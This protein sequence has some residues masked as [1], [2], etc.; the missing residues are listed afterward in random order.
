MNEEF[1]DERQEDVYNVTTGETVT[2]T[3][4]ETVAT[5]PAYDYIHEI[6]TKKKSKVPGIVLLIVGVL[7]LLAGIVFFLM[8]GNSDKL[9]TE[10]A[11]DVYFAS[12]T[13]QYSS[14][15]VQY[16]TDSVASYE[17]MDNM[18]F[19]IT[20]DSEWNPA[21][22]CMHTDELPAFM[23]YM[24]WF[25]SDSEEGAPEEQFFAGYAQPIDEELKEIVIES[26][27]EIFGED[28]VDESN[29]TEWFGEYYLQIG[30]KNSSYGVSNVGIAFLLCA[31]LLIVI[32]GAL[33]YEKPIAEED[34]LTIHKTHTGLGIL[35]AMLGAMLGG[36][37]W[38]IIGA[39][40]F[41][42]GWVGI[43][44]IF[45]AYK[46]YVILARKEGVFGIVISIIF[47]LIIVLPATYLSYGWIYYCALN[48]SVSGYTTLTRALME[49]PAYLTQYE[50]W[51]SFGGDVL[52]GYGFMIFVCIIYGANFFSGRKKEKI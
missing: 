45:F 46:G 13:D 12:S 47:G 30:Q 6:P 11:M 49:L 9:E 35:G 26:F 51:G 24:D 19:F 34:G 40:G 28:I 8:G 33:V 38:T 5:P 4:A 42:S 21:I 36:L 29:F 14:V 52:M 22:V 25:Y 3:D 37:V 16:M 50:E 23:P 7:F 43:L 15:T 2:N 20:M 31:I 48:E 18:Q 39:A 41:V 44:I 1:R 32:G 17:A 10:E 27:A